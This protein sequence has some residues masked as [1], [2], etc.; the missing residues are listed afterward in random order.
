MKISI[1]IKDIGIKNRTCYFFDDIINLKNFDPNNIKIYEK[2]YKKYSY[3]LYWICSNQ[4]FQ[5][6][7]INSVNSL[8]LIFNKVNGY[9]EKIS[10]NM[11]LTLCSSYYREE[12]KN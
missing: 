1:K 11:Y 7:K 3:L 2:A 6:I 5:Y 4:R 12:R 10:G 9:F 8:Y